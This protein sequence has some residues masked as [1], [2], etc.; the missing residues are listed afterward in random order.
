M[1]PGWCVINKINTHIYKDSSVC[2]AVHATVFVTRSL[3]AGSPKSKNA[4]IR[5][6]PLTATYIHQQ[7]TVRYCSSKRDVAL[8][9]V[10]YGS[11]ERYA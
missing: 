4:T 10:T 11:A 9:V 3:L 7:S 8:Y 1:N 5:H 2:S 6:L